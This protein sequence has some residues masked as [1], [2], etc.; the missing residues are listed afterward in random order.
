MQLLKLELAVLPRTSGPGEDLVERGRGHTT[1]VGVDSPV[2]ESDP[3]HQRSTEHGL[4]FLK[5]A[6]VRDSRDH[7]ERDKALIRVVASSLGKESRTS[8]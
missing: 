2:Y 7:L 5:P 1:Q 3:G 8:I 6:A 4:E